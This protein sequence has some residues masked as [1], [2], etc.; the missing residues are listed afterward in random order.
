MND[1]FRKQFGG[2]ASANLVFVVAFF[3]F[4]GLRK[5]CSR[6]SRCHSKFHSCCLEVDIEDRTQRLGLE[7]LDCELYR[8]QRFGGQFIWNFFNVEF[9]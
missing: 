3:L 5:L 4:A 1:E 2:S 6:N 8:P 7:R 9:I